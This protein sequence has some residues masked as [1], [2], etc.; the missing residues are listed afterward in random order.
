MTD[1]GNGQFVLQKPLLQQFVRVTH[2]F[3]R[4][5]ILFLDQ[6]DCSS[7]YFQVYTFYHIG[8]IF[9]QLFWMSMSPWLLNCITLGDIF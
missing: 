1:T 6:F 4:F 9:A 2:N 5:H 3:T 7:L 8:M